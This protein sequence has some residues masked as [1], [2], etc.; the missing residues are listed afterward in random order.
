MELKCS[1][2]LTNYIL[3]DNSKCALFKLKSIENQ[4]GKFAQKEKE[5]TIK[6]KQTK[7]N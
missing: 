4:F 7:M 3:I 1:N 5:I 6:L 2:K